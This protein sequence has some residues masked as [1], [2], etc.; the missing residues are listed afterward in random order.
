MPYL[1][2]AALVEGG[3]TT[4]MLRLSKNIVGFHENAKRDTL[5]SVAKSFT[6]CNY[7][8]VRPNIHITLNLFRV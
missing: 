8:K 2:L 7:A 5:A 6:Y 1:I 3:Y 4:E